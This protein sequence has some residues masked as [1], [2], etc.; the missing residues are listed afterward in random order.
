MAELDPLPEKSQTLIPRNTT[1]ATVAAVVG[2]AALT[3]LVDQ[4]LELA[5]QQAGGSLTL[6]VGEVDVFI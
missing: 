5:V 6:N 2:S 3:A 4:E 1:A